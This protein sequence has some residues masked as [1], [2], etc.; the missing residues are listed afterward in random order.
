MPHRS[1]WVP[2]KNRTV[3]KKGVAVA[4]VFLVALGALAGGRGEKR[5]RTEGSID[6]T[7]V[8][9]SLD[10]RPAGTTTLADQGAAMDQRLRSFSMPHLSGPFEPGTLSLESHAAYQKEGSTGRPCLGTPLA[11]FGPQKPGQLPLHKLSQDSSMLCPGYAQPPT[12]I[13][14][15]EQFTA[16]R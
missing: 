9:A 7:S 1:W 4:L 14:L 10:T 2:Q 5:D 12:P 6:R 15:T 3:D 13:L 11:D 8:S 16:L